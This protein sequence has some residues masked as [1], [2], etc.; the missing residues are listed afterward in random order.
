[1]NS[2]RVLSAIVTEQNEIWIVYRSEGK[3]FWTD[4]IETLEFSL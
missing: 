1:M 3:T 4:L 2:E